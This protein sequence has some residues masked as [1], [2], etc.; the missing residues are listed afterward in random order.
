MKLS[1]IPVLSA[2]LAAVLAPSALAGG[3]EPGSLLI[4]PVHRSGGFF[5]VVSVTNT[6]LVPANQLSLGGTTAAHFQ[7]VNVD[8]NPYNPFRPY[9]CSTFDRVEILT[10]A[11][12]LSVLTTCH[13]A[14][15][16]QQEG[17]LVVAAEDPRAF[18][19]PWSHNWLLGS[20][21]V[22][23]ASGGVYSIEAVALQSPVAAGQPTDLNTNSK[24]DFDNAEY[25]PLPDVLYIDSFVALGGSQLALINFTGEPEDV[26]TVLFSVWNNY[27]FPLSVTLQ[28]NCWFDQPLTRISN[29]FS[30]SFLAGTPHDPRELDLNCNGTSDLQNGWAQIQSIGVRM[31]GGASVS[32]DGAMLGAITAGVISAING[33]RLLAE[34]RTKQSNGSFRYR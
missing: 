26:N 24:Y 14:S 29:L 23:N 20:E 9:G 11:D 6:N 33:G 12:T 27:E 16:P 21:F 22:V 10:P 30:E 19:V 1:M 7:Y 8:P 18:H 5:T 15:G 2:A 3:R 25:Q 31:P 34:S 28:F 4:Y 13:N 17:Y 32:S